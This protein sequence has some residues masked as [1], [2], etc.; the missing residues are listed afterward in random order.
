MGTTA[1]ALALLDLFTIARPSA[2]LSDLSR[3]AGMNK[4]T[5]HRLL[6][7]L[8]DCGF[9]E[10]TGPAREYRVGPAVLRLAALRETTVPTR[11]AALPVLERLARATGETAHMSV[12]VAGRLTTLAFAYGQAHGV[13]VMM[14]DADILPFHA[15]SSGQAVLAFLPAEARA[16]AL[17]APLAAL[18]PATPV[19]PAALSAQAAAIRARGWAET[20]GT[21]EPDVGSLALPL[22]G[23]DAAV[24]GAI[25]L[26]AP[27]ARMTPEARARALPL[28]AGA[29]RE[30]M[31]AWG[32][33][34]PADIGR[35]WDA[36]TGMERAAE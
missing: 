15:T 14:N 6:S 8:A 30:V 11:S 12:L 13:R 29:A 24:A 3:L 27:Q 23:A 36:F 20:E 22:F 31:A 5:C 7:E 21:F 33:H 32:G 17:A 4:A 25:G 2:G 16:A 19:D 34:L 26:A 18:T 9:L 1:K 35:L 10:Q 28:A